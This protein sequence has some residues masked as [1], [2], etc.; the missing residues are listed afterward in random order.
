MQW[1]GKVDLDPIDQYGDWLA[2][3][4]AWMEDTGARGVLISDLRAG[5][6]PSPM[7]RRRIADIRAA[8]ETQLRRVMVDDLVVVD[9]PAVRG[10]MTAIGWVKPQIRM[11]IV[12]SLDKALARA[13]EALADAGIEAP[14]VGPEAFD[15]KVSRSAG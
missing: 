1:H 6:R 2:R 15:L 10:V 3:L 5:E 8:M 9:N 14:A 12:P 7:V 11:N 4:V 13:R